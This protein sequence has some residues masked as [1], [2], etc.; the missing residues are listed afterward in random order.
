MV[1]VL[2]KSG[3]IPINNSSD[4]WVDKAP[5]TQ[6]ETISTNSEIDLRDQKERILSKEG[7]P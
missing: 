6:W 3:T 2:R 7:S 4:M 1:V 5:Y